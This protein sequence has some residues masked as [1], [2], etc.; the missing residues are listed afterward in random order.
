ME[1]GYPLPTYPFP[2]VLVSFLQARKLTCKSE[3]QT[4]RRESDAHPG[5]IE[6]LVQTRG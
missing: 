1:R 3:D 6:D 4:V 2:A 5:F